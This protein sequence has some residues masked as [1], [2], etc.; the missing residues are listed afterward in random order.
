MLRST[1]RP[2]TAATVFSIGLLI[3]G[4]CATQTD[5]AA[6]PA[7]I[8]IEVGDTATV[9][10]VA[11][12]DTGTTASVS[13]ALTVTSA[14]ESVAT[15]DE[16]TVTGLAV[17]TAELT[18]TDG[19]YVTTATV[20]VLTVG[21]LPDEVVITPADVACT[22]ESEPVSLAVYAVESSGESADV[23]TNSVFSSSNSTV[24]LVTGAGEV[25]CVNAGTTTVSASYLGVSGDAYVS[26]GDAPPLT[27]N[28]SPATLSCSAGEYS[29]LQT[30]AVWADGSVT[31]VTYQTSYATSD[32]DVA[33]V[34][35]GYIH[36]VSDGDAT[37]VATYNGV[38]DAVSV[39]VD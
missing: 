39:A 3:L 21:T 7:D 37:I 29:T 25:V 36:C 38:T 15:V 30:L 26:V 11:V 34:T 22:T 17:G 28:V 10:V 8:Y 32:T 5:L 20:H 24:A 23:T 9:T 14:D 18:I 6:S 35:L 33:R 12:M 13:P 19:V 31:D 2:I 1:G 4:G 16:D 27:I